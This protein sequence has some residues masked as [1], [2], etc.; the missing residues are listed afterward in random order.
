M[1][2]FNFERWENSLKYFDKDNHMFGSLLTKLKSFRNKDLDQAFDEL[3]RRLKEKG[4]NT[5]YSPMDGASEYLP[6]MDVWV[7]LAD[8]TNESGLPIEKL[9]EKVK[10]IKAINLEVAKQFGLNPVGVG[11]VIGHSDLIFTYCGFKTLGF[12]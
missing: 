7:V 12:F 3:K 5:N 10:E 11:P 6:G 4:Y 9:I 2:D 1:F 8:P